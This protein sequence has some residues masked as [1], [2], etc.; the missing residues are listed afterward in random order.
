[1]KSVLTK[2]ILETE[3]VPFESVLEEKGKVYTF[4]N[5]VSY[6]DALK[7]QELFEMFDGIFVDG[8][9]LVSAIRIVYGK[10]V[11]R[12][13]CDMTSVGE[14]LLAVSVSKG[15]SLYYVASKQ[16]EVEKAINMFQEK[17]PGVNIIGYRNGY[18]VDEEE[19]EQ[20]TKYITKLNPDF[21]VVGMGILKQE[22]FLL[23]VKAAGYQG[24]GFTC[25]GFIHQTAHNEMEYYPAWVDR[26]NI[27]F[28]YRMYKE[29]HTRRRYLMAGLIFPARYVWER[30]FG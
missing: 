24:I 18:F 25:G 11:T 28:L 15:K 16:E 2:K 3:A 9:I 8:S 6:L 13:S 19:M 12:R 5:P 17:F 27:R 26:M 21:L 23:R 22:E 1:M 4:L 20:E 14:A 29:P 10:K 7:H 30:F